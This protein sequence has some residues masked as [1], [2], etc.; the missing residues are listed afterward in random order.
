MHTAQGMRRL[1]RNRKTRSQNGYA[2]LLAV[3]LVALLAITVAAAWPNL[4]TQGR[5]EKEKEMIWRGRQY[6]RGIHLYYRKTGHFPLQL[7]DL[8]KPKMGIRFMRKPYKDPMNTADGSWRLIYVGP[9]GQIIGSVKPQ[10]IPLVGSA[11]TAAAL[12][13]P[14]APPSFSSGDPLSSSPASTISS[15]SSAAPFGSQTP[16]DNTG[17]P[18]PTG[19]GS[20]PGNPTNSQSLGGPQ[21]IAQPT[22]SSSPIAQNA[23]I[24]VGSKIN[25]SSIV[26][27][28]GEKN[29]QRFEFIWKAV[30]VNPAYVTPDP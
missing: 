12:A 28:E 20:T 27:F 26:W 21:P 16:L 14:L 24:G 19:P 9:I 10:V 30:T 5:R 3:F 1:Q 29:Y 6:V 13:G 7:D 2:L 25:K 15:V 22:D 4:I 17:N 18:L 11:P 23:I 8:Y